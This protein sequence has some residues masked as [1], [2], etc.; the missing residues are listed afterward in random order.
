MHVHIISA[1]WT[2]IWITLLLQAFF[3]V[4]NY[5]IERYDQQINFTG[6]SDSVWLAIKLHLRQS[7][8]IRWNRLSGKG[9]LD[10]CLYGVFSQVQLFPDIVLPRCN[11]SGSLQFLHLKSEAVSGGQNKYL[12]SKRTYTCGRER[13]TVFCLDNW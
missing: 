3:Y 11:H 8:S 13:R 5:Y 4:A 10:A 7:I 12:L 1:S 2:I 9:R 6:I